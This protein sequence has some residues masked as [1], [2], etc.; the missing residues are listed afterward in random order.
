[1]TIVTSRNPV[2][3]EITT[4]VVNYV[5][6][7]STNQIVEQ[8]S[9]NINNTPVD[10]TGKNVS[11]VSNVQAIDVKST[12][13][14]ASWGNISKAIQEKQ[15]YYDHLLR[16]TGEKENMVVVQGN[17]M[18]V[19]PIASDSLA[20]GVRR[21]DLTQAR[22]VEYDPY[23]AE[24]YRMKQQ[25]GKY[26]I[27]LSDVTSLKE[28]EKKN[29]D[30]NIK[31][32]Q[33][34][35]YQAVVKPQRQA[36]LQEMLSSGEKQLVRNCSGAVGL[37]DTP[38]YFQSK[39]AYEN[40]QRGLIGVDIGGVTHVMTPSQINEI[41]STVQQIRA[42]QDYNKRVDE[43]NASLPEANAIMKLR[44]VGVPGG[45][46]YQDLGVVQKSLGKIISELPKHQREEFEGNLYTIWEKIGRP[47]G[48]FYKFKNNYYRSPNEYAK[49]QKSEILSWFLDIKKKYDEKLDEVSKLYVIYSE[50]PT[51]TNAMRF[52]KA[53]QELT[54][55]KQQVKSS[56]TTTQ[57]RLDTLSALARVQTYNRKKKIKKSKCTKPKTPVSKQKTHRN[58][59]KRKSE[60][61][62]K[63]LVLPNSQRITSYRERFK[64]ISDAFLGW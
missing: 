16:G 55:L 27:G 23:L 58:R 17:K 28:D 49:K 21:A 57:N 47:S 45:S 18:Y 12:I 33:E 26:G 24:A 62:N 8:G 1:M 10:L 38:E 35:F 52:V 50:N 46:I 9:W 29:L 34:K 54:L 41:N 48:D 37:V 42:A 4:R 44:Q 36:E 32:Y 30:T 59:K 5:K 13:P 15:A 31:Q 2:T 43:Y 61:N 6:D 19:A 63:R 22:E 11:V 14:P 3:G 53:Q 20:H 39:V 51:P 56:I 40:A 64:K 60:P 25:Y 7:P